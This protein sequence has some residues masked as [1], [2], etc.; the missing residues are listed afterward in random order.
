MPK[1]NSHLIN[2]FNRQ[3]LV[4]V[5]KSGL[6]EILSELLEKEKAPA[7]FGLNIMLVR[8]PIIRIYHRDFMG[9]DTPTDVISFPPDE[10]DL[11]SATALEPACGDVV[12]SV[13]FAKKYAETHALPILEEVVRYAIHGSLHCLGFDDLTP[14]ERRK[15]FTRQEKYVTSWRQKFL[16][17]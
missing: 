8:D 16:T 1:A 9:I 17:K 4:S 14:H 10:S 15:M 12:L 11:S 2:L 6:V 3:R 5:K 7:N 13:D